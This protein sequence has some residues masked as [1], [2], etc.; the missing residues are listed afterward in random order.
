MSYLKDF[1]KPAK[2]T[3]AD[4]SLNSCNSSRII[5]LYCICDSYLWSFV[6]SDSIFC[7]V[8]KYRFTRWGLESPLEV[9][10]DTAKIN[11]LLIERV[12]RNFMFVPFSYYIHNVKFIQKDKFDKK[13]S[14]KIVKQEASM[15]FV[16]KELLLKYSNMLA[17]SNINQNLEFN[18]FDY[19]IFSP[20]KEM[21][22][23]INYQLFGKTNKDI[24]IIPG[25]PYLF[26]RTT[27]EPKSPGSSFYPIT[28]EKI[29]DAVVCLD[30]VYTFFRSNGFDEVCFTIAP[31]PVSIICP[32]YSHY[33]NVIKRVQNH[34]KLIM[35]MINIFDKLDS[36]K[37]QVFFNSD[38][39]WN[40]NGFNLWVNEF[41]KYLGTVKKL[42]N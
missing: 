35:P 37:F 9:E 24:C 1:K 21:K 33:N 31:N 36:A 42:R 22:A 41:N 38:T 11:V 39:H 29:H 4:I 13:I 25:Y 32:G 7:G 12:E 40:S 17:N 5:N 28:D 6:I 27:V 14:K 19:A 16:N 20:L 10:L 23:E 3:N 34:P 30:S 8:K 2:K 15:L 26:Y 18:L